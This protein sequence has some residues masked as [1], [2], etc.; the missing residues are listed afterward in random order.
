MEGPVVGDVKR[1]PVA[2]MCNN[3]LASLKVLVANWKRELENAA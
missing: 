1:K 3:Y 2:A